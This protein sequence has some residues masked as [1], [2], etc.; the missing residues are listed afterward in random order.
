MKRD[1]NLSEA[2]LSFNQLD[3][4]KATRNLK[5]ALDS[6]PSA[7]GHALLALCLIPQNRI[8]AARVEAQ[9]GV[10]ED[11]RSA[12]CHYAAAAASEA[13]KHYDAARR[14]IELALELEPQ[15]SAYQIASLRLDRLQQGSDI[16]EPLKTLLSERPNDLAVIYALAECYCDSSEWEQAYLYAGR[17]LRLEATSQRALMLMARVCIQLHKYDEARGHI[18]WVLGANKDNAEAMEL[19]SQIETRDKPV[20][21]GFRMFYKKLQYHGFDALVLAYSVL[22]F[23]AVAFGLTS[24]E[25]FG[26]SESQSIDKRPFVIAFGGLVAPLVFYGAM[27]HFCKRKEKCWI[28]KLTPLI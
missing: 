16:L 2:W 7:E 11:R 6:A 9:R 3:Y 20:W 1:K 25:L 4:E 5:S 17:A 27:G 23:F 19:L 21:R 28:E 10:A 15:T 14:H 22:I 24:P 13:G 12:F 26:V 8:L 18:F